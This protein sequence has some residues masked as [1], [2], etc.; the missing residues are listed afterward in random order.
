MRAGLQA[1][2]VWLVLGLGSGSGAVT[3]TGLRS[4]RARLSPWATQTPPARPVK[5]EGRQAMAA[6]WLPLG[7]L[8]ICILIPSLPERGVTAASVAERPQAALMLA[9]GPAGAAA[10]PSGALA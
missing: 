9:R 7:L 4:R 2:V 10:Q 8:G 5:K 6:A 3:V 1:R